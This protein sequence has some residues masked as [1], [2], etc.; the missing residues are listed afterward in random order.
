MAALIAPT[1]ACSSRLEL[2]FGRIHILARACAV[3][4]SGWFYGK[5]GCCV[6]LPILTHTH[7]LASADQ[8]PCQQNSWV[9]T[10][11][12]SYS[13]RADAPVSSSAGHCRFH[14]LKGCGSF[15]CL[16]AEPRFDRV[17]RFPNNIAMTVP[18]ELKH[19]GIGVK[20]KVP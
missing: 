6:G 15:R 3:L 13:S 16:L 14:R 1:S 4:L 12:G 17:P 5:L 18:C 10:G 8:R 7:L 20:M 19:L 2:C 11:A 9:A